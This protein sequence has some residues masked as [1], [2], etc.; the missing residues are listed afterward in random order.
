MSDKIKKCLIVN[1]LA[2]SGAGKST[3]AARL[4]AYLKEA[5]V[6]VELVSEWVKD[7]VWEGRSQIFGCQDYIYGKQLWKQMR[8]ADKVDVIVTDSPIILSALYDPKQRKHFKANIFETFNEFNNLNFFLNRVKPF[9]PNGRN[10]KTVEEAINNDNKLRKMLD[11]N[12]IEYT[13]VDGSE[14]GCKEIYN[15]VMKKL[16]KEN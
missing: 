12:D 15:A 4:Y 3:N 9:N 7:M 14:E 6:E 1:L 10:E 13:V 16:N 11:E 2:G 5:G 8:V